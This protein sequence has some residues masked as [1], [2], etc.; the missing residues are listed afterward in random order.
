VL[1][2]VVL[3][4][5]PLPIVLNVVVLELLFLIVHVQLTTILK[6]LIGLVLNV[7]INVLLVVLMKHA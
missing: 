5:H 2:N 4:K 6:N 3:V 1:H 7:L